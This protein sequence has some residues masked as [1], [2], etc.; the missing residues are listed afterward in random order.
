MKNV[1]RFGSF[2]TDEGLQEKDL[3]GREELLPQIAR[4]LMK[5]RTNDAMLVGPSADT[6]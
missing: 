1:S 2:L 4:A 3:C 6:P 5:M